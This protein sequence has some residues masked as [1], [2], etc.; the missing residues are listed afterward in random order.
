MPA[1]AL[2]EGDT[3]TLCCWG[4]RNPLVT[5]SL[6]VTNPP[7]I[8]FPELF[9]VSLLEGPPELTEGAPLNLSCISTPSPLLPPAPFLY[10]LYRQL[11]GS[12]QGSPQILVPAVGVSHSGN[13]SCKVHSEGDGPCGRAGVRLGVTVRMPVVDATITPGPLAFQVRPG[14]PVTLRCSVQVG[15]APV[16]F[17]WLRNGLEVARGPLLELGA[18]DQWPVALAGP[19]TSWSCSWLELLAGTSGTTC[20]GDNGDNGGPGEMGG[21]T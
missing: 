1:R 18:V 21:D 19:S 7:P 2:L 8:A 11:V 6:V 14:V 17:T 16:T 5:S 9:S 12:S 3:V 10:C 15:S 13:Y 20:V 4:W